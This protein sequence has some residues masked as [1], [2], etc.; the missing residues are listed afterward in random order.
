M[1]PAHE[2]KV[3]S[4]YSD[5][6]HE[7]VEMVK[8]AG[9]GDIT[10]DIF[11]KKLQ[12]KGGPLESRGE[13]LSPWYVLT[14]HDPNPEQ[15]D[16]L[17]AAY[18]TETNELFAP[19]N[20]KSY[21]FPRIQDD[22]GYEPPRKMS[23]EDLEEVKNGVCEFLAAS[24]HPDKDTID[25]NLF[26]VWN[27]LAQ[28]RYET[29][30][31]SNF[32]SL[33]RPYS[34]DDYYI[35][36]LGNTLGDWEAFAVDKSNLETIKML[37]ITRDSEQLLTMAK[38]VKA[39]KD[40]EK[41]IDL[42]FINGVYIYPSAVALDKKEP[43]FELT[44]WD[45]SAVQAGGKGEI[46]VYSYRVDEKITKTGEISMPAPS[47]D[48]SKFNEEYENTLINA[49]AD[50][51]DKIL[52]LSAEKGYEDL[53]AKI[54]DQGFQLLC[55]PQNPWFVL[56]IDDLNEETNDD[57]AAIYQTKTND[58][59]VLSKNQPYIFPRPQRNQQVLIP[60]NISAEAAEQLVEKLYAQL[61]DN[62][63]PYQDKIDTNLYAIQILAEVSAWPKYSDHRIEDDDYT[64]YAED[65]I[66]F[67]GDT[68]SYWEAFLVDSDT[69]KPIKMVGFTSE[70][71]K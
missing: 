64:Q 37:G 26:V 60:E 18:N 4:M 12:L 29:Y 7:I 62:N 2:E 52:Q 22:K 57:L 70:Q 28:Y 25:T 66:V 55:A 32:D 31:N 51:T 36:I 34:S 44:F 56:M 45:I 63:H 15:P 9:H 61:K 33:R 8:E 50:Q 40:Q 38:P 71:A 13:Y 30:T 6:I 46:T 47:I 53:A 23:A 14:I 19:K 59:F 49:L 65:Y 58:L 48:Y 11:A 10:A 41:D 67:L 54:F 69:L 68:F 21:I 39:V 3:F 1:E 5:R 27:S 17:A 43:V 24:D 20:N 42:T 16:V 35:V